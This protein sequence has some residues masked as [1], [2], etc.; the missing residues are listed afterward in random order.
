MVLEQVGAHHNPPSRTI[1]SLSASTSMAPSL[2]NP[3]PAPEQPRFANARCHGT[4]G[5]ALWTTCGT[6][7]MSSMLLQA[8][9]PPAASFRGHLS[10][11]LLALASGLKFSGALSSRTLIMKTRLLRPSADQEEPKGSPHW[12]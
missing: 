6:T 1:A 10:A 3:G 12:G 5:H 4:A 2:V 9:T 7:S 8:M 11:G